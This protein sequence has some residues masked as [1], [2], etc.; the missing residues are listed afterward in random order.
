[1]KNS[2]AS[3]DVPM[4]LDPLEFPELAALE[5][6]F[7]MSMM[8]PAGG[9]SG[10]VIAGQDPPPRKQQQ[11][12]QGSGGPGAVSGAASSGEASGLTSSAPPDPPDMR[13]LK[14]AKKNAWFGSDTEMTEFAYKVR[15]EFHWGDVMSKGPQG[16]GK[17]LAHTLSCLI[18]LLS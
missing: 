2:A 5:E 7:K 11:R 1:M 16:N 4:E 12:Q 9:A 13:A 8:A 18:V 10:R 15:V 3:L 6:Q 17:F 14:W